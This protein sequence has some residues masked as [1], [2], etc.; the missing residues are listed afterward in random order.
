MKAA[1]KNMLITLG[2]SFVVSG[3]V[4]WATNNTRTGKDLL[5]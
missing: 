1:H 2:I 4:V 3:L 5:G